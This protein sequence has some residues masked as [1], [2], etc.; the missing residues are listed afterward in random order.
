M[1]SGPRFLVAEGNTRLRCEETSRAG[2][3]LGS[4]CYQQSLLLLCPNAT[5]DILYVA[6][7]ATGL[8][9]RTQLADYDGV[10]IGGSALNIPGHEDV[11]EIVRQIEFARAVFES[12]IPFFGSCWGMQIA[13]VT[14]GGKVNR[15]PRGR[16]LGIARKLTLTPEGRRA[17]LFDGKASVFDAM[18]IH[19]DEVTQLPPAAELLA[20][21]VHSQIQAVSI[22]YRGGTFWGV[23]YHPEFDVQHTASVIEDYAQPLIKEGFFDGQAALDNHTTAMKALANNPDRTDLRSQLGFGDDVLDPQIRLREVRNWITCQVEPQ[24]CPG[25]SDENANV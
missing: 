22:C 21:N 6:E 9:C 5:V 3:A 13:T 25:R 24:M 16:E 12:G 10:V 19:L 2:I 18:A 4:E 14:A 23:Q 20:S 8:P 15:N 17:N 1:T 7:A 11:P